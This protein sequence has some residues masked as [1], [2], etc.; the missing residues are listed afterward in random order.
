[1]GW[2]RSGCSNCREKRRLQENNPVGVEVGMTREEIGRTRPVA[3]GAF[4]P[5]D[6]HRRVGGKLR[7]LEIS[8]KSKAC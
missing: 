5:Q 3:L 6:V 4:L 8:L 2:R 7:T 1:M